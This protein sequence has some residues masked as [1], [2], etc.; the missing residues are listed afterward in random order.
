MSQRNYV[1]DD[2]CC[3]LACTV[4]NA[5]AAPQLKNKVIEVKLVGDPTQETDFRRSV[6]IEGNLV[7]VGVGADG[8]NGA[9]YIYKQN[10]RNFVLDNK[11]E[12][13]DDPAG[14][15]FGRSVAIKGMVIVGARF[16]Q[17]AYVIPLK[18]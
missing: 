1:C 11:L 5:A 13:P 7:A 3:F 8:D 15:E 6:A 12:C 16:A 2:A 4:G 17:A 10:G 18:P 14:A 9:V